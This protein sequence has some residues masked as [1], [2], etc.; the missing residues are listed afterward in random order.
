MFSGALGAVGVAATVGV[1]DQPANKSGFA[2]TSLVGEQIAGSNS[3]KKLDEV[4]VAKLAVKLQ[5]EPTK[6][7]PVITPPV[8]IPSFDLLRVEKDG[9]TLIAGR[10]QPD[11]TIEIFDGV[12]IVATTEAG[13]NGDFVAIL[14]KPLSPGDHQLGIRATGKDSKIL[15][16]AETGLVSVPIKKDGELLAMVMKPGEASRI[17]Q[18]PTASKPAEKVKT[19]T[20]APITST[21]TSAAKPADQVVEITSVAPESKSEVAIET[22]V[23]VESNSL[24]VARTGIA[25]A[26][27][28]E[29]VVMAEKK[30]DP[31]EKPAVKDTEQTA[32]KV[33][34]AKVAVPVEEAAPVKEVEAAPIKEI[35]AIEDQQVAALVP[36]AKSK[37]VS[38]GTPATAP[39]NKATTKSTVP[40]KKPIVKV[41][42]EKAPIIIVEAVEIDGPIMFIAGAAEPG[43]RVA[44]YVDNKLIGF[45]DGSREGRFLLEVER[46]LSRGGH[47]VRADIYDAK[48][49]AV[50][51]RAEVPLIHEPE[52]PAVVVAEVEKVEKPQ[53]IAEKTATPAELKTEPEEK[54]VQIAKI[55]PSSPVTPA[56]EPKVEPAK[57]IKAPAV[58][59]TTIV[60]KSEEKP[61]IKAIEK[62]PEKPKKGEEA[63]VGVMEAE[64]KPAAK[65][66][67]VKPAEVPAVAITDQPEKTSVAAAPVEP[68][69][70][71]EPK[72]SANMPPAKTAEK[73]AVELVKTAP[74]KSPEKPIETITKA[75]TAPVQ[76]PVK[77]MKTATQPAP[78]VMKDVKVASTASVAAPNRRVLRT[79]SS[80]IIRRGDSLWRI[81]YRTY[82]RGIRY[83][84]IY[85][86]N[87]N[88]LRSPHRIYPGQILKVPKKNFK[89]QG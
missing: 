25:S 30:S 89:Q 86:A 41:E 27:V 69:K 9:S 33:E 18:K 78:E 12:I 84:T 71:E 22:P 36:S 59:S 70:V 62:A 63:K 82:G 28:K 79:G 52:E 34:P 7:E 31:T 8:I 48:G 65:S 67:S 64:K 26:P 47:L 5:P 4:E 10:A 45:A 19:A 1:F 74:F 58:P 54:K 60:K 80:V 44:V 40:T 88:Q 75:P 49:I 13:S 35:E 87:L 72:V 29:A 68:E 38:A 51:S 37:T 50:A 55:E 83:S 42:P 85:Q 46:K 76:A 77:E 6:K 21:I 20:L 32:A 81:S 66:V 61:A 57:H 11:S 56:V 23:T 43:R 14:E 53:R 73:P 24:V 17:I 15:V 16:S 2:K 3:P 39:V